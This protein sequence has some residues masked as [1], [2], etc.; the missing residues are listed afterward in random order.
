NF[1]IDDKMTKIV[2]KNVDKI[3]ISALYFDKYEQ[4]FEELTKLTEIG[5][6][7]CTQITP[8][9]IKTALVKEARGE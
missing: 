1:E 5:N 9:N 7:N 2:S 3:Q 6:G 4:Y 8:D